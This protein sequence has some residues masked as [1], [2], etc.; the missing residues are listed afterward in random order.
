MAVQRLL[1]TRRGDGGLVIAGGN[2]A[3]R[4]RLLQSFGGTSQ[5]RRVVDIGAEARLESQVAALVPSIV[6][7]DVGAKPDAKTFSIISSLSALAKTIVVAEHDDDALAIRVLKAGASGFCPR[8]TPAALLRKAVQLV[9]AGEIWIGRRVML[10]LIEELAALHG[11]ARHHLGGGGQ[12]T[13]RETAIASLVARGA[14]NK[15]IAQTLSISVKTV[16]THLT[17]IFKKLGLSSRL[18]LGLAIKPPARVQTKV[19]ETSV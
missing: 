16:K 3:F 1:S 2:P 8:T 19:V 10:R 17:N 9:E 18:Q 14:G 6:L 4:R 13:G 11:G 12:L 15:E 5:S 7:F